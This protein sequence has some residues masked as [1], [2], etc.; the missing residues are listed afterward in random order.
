M[1]YF[2]LVWS[3]LG[4]KKIRTILTL[5]SV[6]VAFVLFGYLSAIEEALNQGVSV[7]GADRIVV[8]HKTSI[9]Q[10]LPVSYQARIGRIEGV[11]GVAHSTWFGGIYQDPKNFFNQMAVVPEDFLRLY[12][13][14]VLPPDQREAWE[15]TRTGAIVGKKTAQRFGFEIG[16]RIPIQATIWPKKDG[17][18]TWEFDIVGIYEGAESG[19]DETQLFFRY[20]YLDE[21][22]AGREGEVGWYLVNVSN[23][24]Q[25]EDI[26]AKIDEEFENSLAETRAE[27]ELAFVQGFAKQVGN[28]GAI[29]TAILSAVFFTILLV[30]GNT[31]AQAVRERVVEIGVLKSIGFTDQRILVLVLVESCSIALLGGGMGL[32]LAWVLILSGDPTGGALPVFFFPLP[33]IL[34]GICLALA[35]GVATGVAPAYRAMRLQIAEALRRN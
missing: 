7:A 10:L 11:S 24:D 26:A 5:L 16:D 1:K 4:R 6:G 13:E 19:T 31:M 30:A 9:I 2:Y 33:R 21:A 18:Q 32:A 20:D 29:M 34:M 15:R 35:L 8:R 22:R 17:G 28:I 27:T 14:F 23:P 25:A 3:N 12:P